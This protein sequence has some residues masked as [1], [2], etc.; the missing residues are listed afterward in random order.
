MRMLLV[1]ALVVGL[2]GAAAAV[3]MTRPFE[4][5]EETRRWRLESEKRNAQEKA[6]QLQAAREEK[7]KQLRAEREQ[8]V[9]D[10]AEAKRVAAEKVR[11][12]AAKDK[13]SKTD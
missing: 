5:L 8:K 7:A 10:A 1:T 12:A 13:G 4:V 3:E 2:S 9:K 11:D 6:K